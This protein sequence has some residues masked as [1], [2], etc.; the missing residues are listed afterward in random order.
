MNYTPEQISQIVLKVLKEVN[1]FVISSLSLEE[2]KDLAKNTNTPPEV[3]DCLAGDENW[4]V[5]DLVARNPNTHPKT[6]TRLANDEENWVRYW[7]A[8]NPNTHPKTLTRLAG[9]KDVGVR[10]DVAQ[11]PNTPPET[12]DRLS[13]E[14]SQPVRYD[15]AQNPNTTPET[16]DRL[17][18]DKN[19]W[20]RKVA[21]SNPNYNPTTT[22]TL[23][24]T[25]DFMDEV[26]NMAARE[27]IT[28]GDIIRRAMGLYS[29]TQSE[30]A[31]GNVLSFVNK[32]TNNIEE[33]IKL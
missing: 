27:N 22:Y 33:S 18:D 25:K 14:E 24:C 30:E 3:L 1:T 4:Y 11:N 20:V 7:V 2:K 10:T 32:E 31:K 23:H 19:L 13:Y 29:I 17:A 21:R 26:D 15:V 5:R 28:R 8:R 9:D 6:L 16:L 12:L